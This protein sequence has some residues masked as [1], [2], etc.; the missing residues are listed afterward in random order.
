MHAEFAQ[1]KFV[2][3]AK[4]CLLELPHHPPVTPQENQIYRVGFPGW[5]LAER[6]GVPL[7]FGVRVHKD[8]AFGTYW[9]ES[10]DMDGL[11]VSGTD[12]DDLQSEIM[13]AAEGLL[14]LSVN[15][16]RRLRVVAN[17]MTHSPMLAV[18]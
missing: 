16:T 5:K 1:T 2:G 10:N 7:V 14:S 11:V 4:I 9:A 8:E 17:I 12:L 13:G 18:A 6:L 3:P 15:T